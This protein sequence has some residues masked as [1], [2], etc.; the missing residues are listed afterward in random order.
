MPYDNSEFLFVIRSTKKLIG[1][2]KE[3][4]RVRERRAARLKIEICSLLGN[5][6]PK[7]EALPVRGIRSR[8]KTPQSLASTITMRQLDKHGSPLFGFR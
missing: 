4:Y 3:V 2:M 7:S 5:R 8:F 6:L 1:R